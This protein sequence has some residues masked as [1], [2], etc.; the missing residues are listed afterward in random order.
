MPDA[1]V[2]VKDTDS[3]ATARS[4]RVGY[5]IDFNRYFYQYQP[6]RPLAE[7]D[8]ELRVLERESPQCWRR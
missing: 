2:N 6:P 7:I 5:E 4:A 8:A 1:W 3:A